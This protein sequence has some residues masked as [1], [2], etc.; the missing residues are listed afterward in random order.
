MVMLRTTDLVW[1][2]MSVAGELYTQYSGGVLW[3]FSAISS[4]N[5]FE[6]TEEKKKGRS[7]GSGRP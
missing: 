4:V 3:I 7:D 2:L 5:W 1:R 6:E